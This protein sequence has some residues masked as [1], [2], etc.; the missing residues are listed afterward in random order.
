M[1]NILYQHFAAQSF[2]K[3]GWRRA[4]RVSCEFLRLTR[5]NR[6]K[7]LLWGSQS[8]RNA[9]ESLSSC[10]SIQEISPH[11]CHFSSSSICF[12]SLFQTLNLSLMAWSWAV[13]GSMTPP[14]TKTAEPFANWPLQLSHSVS[15]PTIMTAA[16]LTA[17]NLSQPEN[18]FLVNLFFSFLYGWNIFHRHALD[19]LVEGLT[20][21]DLSNGV[22]IFVFVLPGQKRVAEYNRAFRG[23]KSLVCASRKPLCSLQR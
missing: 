9:L 12:L 13:D 20:L 14:F 5:W 16:A 6:M 11:A 10:L 7:Y 19:I 8:K 18:R 2:V 21:F 1:S 22:D 17:V 4:S 3:T 23:R 15:S